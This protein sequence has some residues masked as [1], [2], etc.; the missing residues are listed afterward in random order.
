M[1]LYINDLSFLLKKSG[2]KFMEFREQLR[3]S[4]ESDRSKLGT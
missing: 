4:I 1:L 3:L 2:E